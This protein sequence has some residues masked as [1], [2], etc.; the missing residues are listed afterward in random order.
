MFSVANCIPLLI[1]QNVDGSDFFNRSW[2]EFKL[3]FNDTRGNFW[4]GNDLLSQLTLTDHYKLKF[5]LQSRAN[6]NWYYAQY[7]TFLVSNETT[8]YRLQVA[9]VETTVFAIAHEWF[10]WIIS[11]I[12][13]APVTDRVVSVLNVE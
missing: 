7:S 5:D 10:E 11:P 3:G 4:L 9:G 2:A 13:C 6:S 8:N 12:D 1:Q